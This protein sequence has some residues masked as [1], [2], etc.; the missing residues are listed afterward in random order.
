MKKLLLLL[1]FLCLV[2]CG[3]NTG[4]KDN[5]NTS[6]E[7]KF[8]GYAKDYYEKYSVKGFNEVDISL[9]ALKQANDKTKSNYD[10][11][12]FTNCDNSSYVKLIINTNTQKINKVEY[13]LSCK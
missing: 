1:I 3:K 8:Y 4:A 13:H 2:G 9:D 7:N 11:S 5:N 12:G 6:L 10:L